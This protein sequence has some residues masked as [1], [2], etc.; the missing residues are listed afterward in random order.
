VALDFDVAAANFYREWMTRVREGQVNPDWEYYMEL[1][2]REDSSL[3]F[4]LYKTDKSEST[5]KQLTAQATKKRL[6][7]DMYR[8][9]GASYFV[10]AHNHP[11]GGAVMPSYG[12]I[13]SVANK[14]SDWE[15]NGL[16]IGT[17][18]DSWVVSDS[19]G[20]LYSLRKDMAYSLDEAGIDKGQSWFTEEYRAG[21]LLHFR[22]RPSELGAFTN[23]DAIGD[24][25]EVRSWI[26][27]LERIGKRWPDSP[28]ANVYKWWRG[29]R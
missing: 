26:R 11:S 12:D 2:F 15:W 4:V 20:A 21:E 13:V 25:R 6:E 7:S 18:E 8:E 10:D 19:F 22:G 1:G 28:W 9:K 27:V 3:A 14:I 16:P 24:E 23:T 29:Q 17:Y 5:V